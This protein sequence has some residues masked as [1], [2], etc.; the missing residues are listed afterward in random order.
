MNADYCPDTSLDNVDNIIQFLM[1]E[2]QTQTTPEKST[3]TQHTDKSRNTRTRKRVHHVQTETVP[4]H[5]MSDEN[6]YPD[7]TNSFLD[8]SRL[9]PETSM[10]YTVLTDSTNTLFNHTSS[11]TKSSASH[12]VDLHNL[13]LH[14]SMLQQHKGLTN[15]T[16]CS[17][18]LPLHMSTQSVLPLD[19]YKL[20]QVSCSVDRR[21]VNSSNRYHPWRNN[22]ILP[23]RGY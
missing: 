2:K 1:E 17:N 23:I 15:S 11:H 20:T 6:T 13:A 19:L 21:K 5:S 16:Q 8:T 22:T 3:G 18:L 12:P 10:G 14:N 9:Q 4:S 7:H